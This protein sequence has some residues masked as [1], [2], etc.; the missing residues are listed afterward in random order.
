MITARASRG[1]AGADRQPGMPRQ[2][3]QDSSRGVRGVRQPGGSPDR[4]G[5]TDGLGVEA[6][7]AGVSPRYRDRPKRSVMKSRKTRSF[8]VIARV[9]E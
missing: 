8:G 4:P 3:R 7:T 1:T 5:R 2:D 6:R 9:G